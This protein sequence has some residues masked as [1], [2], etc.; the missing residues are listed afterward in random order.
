ME[1]LTQKTAAFHTL[2]CKLNFAETSTIARQ[3]T[4]A[5][6][7]KVSFDERA[8]VYVINTCSVTENADRECKFHVK[9]AMKAN[10][11]G[12]VVILGC[13]AQLKPE[14]I[15]GIEGVDLVLGA[16]EKFNLLS[17][18]DDLQKSADNGIIHSCEVDQADFFI[19][20]YSIGD[21]TRAFLKVQDGCDYKCTYCT[22]PLARGISRSDTIENVVKNAA[23][24]ASR[25]IR[26]IVLTGVNIGDYG[27]GEF[28]NKKHEHTFLDLIS[29]LDT[30]EGIERI[31]ISSIEPNLLKD[32]SIELV[33][34]SKRFVPHFHI[35]LQSGSDDLLKKM[36]RRYMSGL[37]TNR[38]QK[39]REVI[40]DACIGVDVI[41]GFPGE[42]EEKFLETYRFLNELPISYLH[43]FTY[44]EREN[45]EAVEM[46]GV[47]PI[48]ERKKRSKMLR[49]LS[50]KKKMA[51]YETQLGKT[52]PVLWEHENKNGFMFG[53]TE[54][55]VRVKK[56]FDENSINQIEN[57]KLQKIE[58]D[59]T[60]SVHAAFEAFLSKV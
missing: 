34:K 32:E 48:A 46:D 60:V 27:K 24:I 9:R 54:N 15:S 56:A 30:V 21:R 40:P 39:I 2:G 31:R 5:G 35:P 28:G 49:I 33:A 57:L 12:L 14:E 29:E 59:G 26:E 58:N 43:V 18:L 16:K 45:T 6:Y 20:S 51:F 25:G 47:I 1:H 37:Y 42:T 3:L 10:P 22:I 7:A 23:E 52:L 41:V 53:F 38:V 36:K 8:H 13:Y 19:G 55:Y 50:E 4:G 11:D 44:S 17:Y